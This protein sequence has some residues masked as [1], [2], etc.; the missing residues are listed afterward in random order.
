MAQTLALNILATPN[1]FVPGPFAA[2]NDVNVN[3]NNKINGNVATATRQYAAVFWEH[4]LDSP[5]A[6]MVLGEAFAE[7]N[8]DRY[9]NAIDLHQINILGHLQDQLKLNLMYYVNGLFYKEAFGIGKI[10]VRYLSHDGSGQEM[11]MDVTEETWDV[12]GYVL[13]REHE[14]EPY[15]LFGTRLPQQGENPSV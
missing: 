5:G 3:G 10:L 13:S 14:S 1:V 8:E 2:S 15:L 12:V 9:Y 11:E 4:Q 7:W 6:A